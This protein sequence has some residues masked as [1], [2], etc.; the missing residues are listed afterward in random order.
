[1]LIVTT[2]R[3][4]HHQHEHCRSFSRSTDFRSRV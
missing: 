4:R 2:C 3:S 1:M